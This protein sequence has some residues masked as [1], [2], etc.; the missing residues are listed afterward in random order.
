MSFLYEE[1]VNR[2]VLNLRPVWANF[3]KDGAA[4][5]INTNAESPT[6]LG[7]ITLGYAIETPKTDYRTSL[8]TLFEYG[9]IT[10]NI[11]THE[12]K[13]GGTGTDGQPGYLLLA[14]GS[15]GVGGSVAAADVAF[16]NGVSQTFPNHYSF[17]LRQHINVPSGEYPIGRSSSWGAGSK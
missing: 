9:A 17:F 1:T 13:G 6:G 8:T 16:T 10:Q 3:Y 11:A 5:F 7:T 4:S 12:N 2:K 15:I 14:P